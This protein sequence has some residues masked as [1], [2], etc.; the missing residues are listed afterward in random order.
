MICTCTLVTSGTASI[1]NVSAARAPSN[2]KSS[3]STKTMARLA[4]RPADEGAKRGTSLVLRE[5]ALEHDALEREDAVRHYLFASRSRPAPPHLAERFLASVT[6]CSSNSRGDSRTNTTDFS[7][8]WVTLDC[9]TTS[10]GSVAVP[11]SEI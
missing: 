11:P 3:V 7:P 10:L 8:I 5:R 2:T 6:S 1:G 9:E 4:R